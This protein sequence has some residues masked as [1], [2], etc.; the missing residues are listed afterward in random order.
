MTE[1]IEKL[2][3]NVNKSNLKRHI[4]LNHE[5]NEV[6]CES[7]MNA[8]QK[9]LYDKSAIDAKSTSNETEG[10]KILD[11]MI[12]EVEKLENDEKSPAQLNCKTSKYNG[13]KSHIDYIYEFVINTNKDFD[14][15]GKKRKVECHSCLQILNKQTAIELVFKK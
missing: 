10:I 15:V 7:I 1:N 5:E 2:K 9:K 11:N 6:K 4:K 13:L 12:K 3:S 8:N 14:Q